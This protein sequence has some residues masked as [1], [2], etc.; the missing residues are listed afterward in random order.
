MNAEDSPTEVRCNLPPSRES[1][2]GRWLSE[3]LGNIFKFEPRKNYPLITRWLVDDGSFVTKGQ[4]IVELETD[5][6]ELEIEAKT[7]GTIVQLM[8]E[9]QPVTPDDLIAVIQL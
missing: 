3:S 1:L 5:K 8:A 9:G 6:I 7:Q 4:P 2:L